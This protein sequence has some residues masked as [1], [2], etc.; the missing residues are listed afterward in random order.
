MSDQCPD[1]SLMLNVGTSSLPWAGWVVL[2]ASD[3]ER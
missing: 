1:V 2:E 3:L